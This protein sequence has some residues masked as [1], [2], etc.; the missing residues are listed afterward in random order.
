MKAV[1]VTS[2]GDIDEA[3]WNAL[4]HSDA[5]F[6]RHEFLSALEDSGC[7][8]TD[9]GWTPCHLVVYG[10][11]QD[12]DAG[13]API[14]ALPLYLKYHSYGEYVFDWAWAD[15]Y[16][17]SGLKY[18]PK[19]LSSVPFTPVT[20][21]RMLIG[22]GQN[23]E[24]VAPFLMRGA[25]TVAQK[26]DLSSFHCLFIN[27]QDN[28]DFNRQDFMIRNGTQF[29][30]HNQNYA[31]FDDFLQAFSSK[32]R[33]KVKRE[34]RRVREA[35][36]HFVHLSGDDID[37]A[38]WRQ[39]Y[40]FYRSTI[41]VRGAMAYLN[42]DFF[43]RIGATMNDRVLL[44][45]AVRDGEYIAGALNLKGSET[46][47]GRYWGCSDPIADLHFET[48][49]Y[50]GIEYCID[51]GLKR[52]EAGAQGEHKLQRGLLPVITRSAHWI[53]HPQFA[54]AI[55]DYLQ[56]EEQGVIRYKH[57]LD[58]HS[59]FK[60]MGDGVSTKNNCSVGANAAGKR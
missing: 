6:L 19:L 22:S 59:P 51:H 39:Y 32:N 29:H 56:R 53:S 21:P 4:V 8:S 35:G 10:D 43:K 54:E 27:D 44:T 57:A 5:P 18:Y 50:Q 11:D 34:R 36:V 26:Y 37:E 24:L 40:E 25:L 49:Y 23:R 12:I 38:T 41:D 33:K 46:L 13:D 31:D 9:T 7:V 14:A 28:A 58:E 47:Y 16:Q 20:G 15:A 1:T 17:R 2:I 3:H 60:S 52:F 48:C 45:M 55:E 30:W 42:L